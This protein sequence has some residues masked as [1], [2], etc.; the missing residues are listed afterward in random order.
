MK[1]IHRILSAAVVLAV[2]SASLSLAQER[3]R[4]FN[5][6]RPES[7]GERGFSQRERPR[8]FNGEQDR[9]DG[10]QHDGGP[11]GEMR[12]RGGPGGAG[13]GDQAGFMERI[14]QNPRVAEE[15]ELTEEQ[16]QSLKEQAETA[17]QQ[18]KE[19][20]QRLMKA[21]KEQVQ[22]MMGEDLNEEALISKIRETGD[23]RTEIA[24][25]RVR[26]LI[27]MKKTLTNEQREKMK[28]MHQRIRGHQREKM[29]RMREKFKD[30]RSRKDG[31]R[32]VDGE[33]DRPMRRS[34][35]NGESEGDRRPGRPFR[36]RDRDK[37]RDKERAER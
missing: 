2:F 29:D 4:D 36:D 23:I 20:Q 15:L 19:L 31:S 5:R 12:G 24:I 14:L 37:E 25:L 7:G 8:G 33:R 22:L 35:T 16:V 28:Q 17:R 9:R 30:E 10:R 26:Q 3:E 27:N 21:G 1:A 18:Q 11:G 32:G 34:F 13:G 6:K